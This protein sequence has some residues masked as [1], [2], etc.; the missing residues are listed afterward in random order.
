MPKSQYQRDAN[1]IVR[2]DIHFFNMKDGESKK[3][4]FTRLKK[5]LG[6]GKA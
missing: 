4:G 6:E 2:V 1:T 5:S 3:E